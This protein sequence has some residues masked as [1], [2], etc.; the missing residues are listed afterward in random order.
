MGRKGKV[1]SE[2]SVFKTKGKNT[3]L[4]GQMNMYVCMYIF[5]YLFI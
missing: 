2:S 5:I 1:L 4:G 3:P